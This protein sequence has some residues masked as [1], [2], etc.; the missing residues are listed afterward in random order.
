MP[1]LAAPAFAETHEKAREAGVTARGSRPAGRPA[2]GR[3]RIDAKMI[4]ARFAAGRGGG[5]PSGRR[6]AAGGPLKYFSVDSDRC[7]RSLRGNGRKSA[8]GDFMIEFQARKRIFRASF[9]LLES[10]GR[11]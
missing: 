4:S 6:D 8:L 2:G 11:F 7:V 3:S 10:G 9:G 1:A 5:V